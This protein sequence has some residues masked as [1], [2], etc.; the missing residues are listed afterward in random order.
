M[1][2]PTQQMI[3]N[4]KNAFNALSV[5]GLV[6]QVS[7]MPTVFYTCGGNFDGLVPSL[8]LDIV[9]GLLC[10]LQVGLIVRSNYLTQ[11][12]YSKAS[13]LFAVMAVAN[14]GCLVMLMLLWQDLVQ[15]CPVPP[16]GDNLHTNWRTQLDTFFKDSYSSVVGCRSTPADQ[17]YSTLDEANGYQMLYNAKEWCELALVNSCPN[18]SAGSTM[19]RCLR[20]G[21]KHFLPVIWY[22]FEIDLLYTGFRLLTCVMCWRQYSA[23][24]RGGGNTPTVGELTDQKEKKLQPEYHPLLRHRRSQNTGALDF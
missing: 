19:E 10:L 22:A 5:G 15:D 16:T 17:C 12:E 23:K 18:L 11:T 6:W 24:V 4:L 7:L 14:V 8:V 21:A 20:Y 3:V 9:G 1:T 2:D 13:K